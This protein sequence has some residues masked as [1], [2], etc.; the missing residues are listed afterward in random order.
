MRRGRSGDRT[1]QRETD[2]LREDQGRGGQN[3]IGKGGGRGMVD[4][5]NGGQKRIALG[6]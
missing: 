6:L 4:E 2:G 5:D 3:R 1:E